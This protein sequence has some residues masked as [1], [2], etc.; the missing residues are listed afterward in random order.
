MLKIWV[1]TWNRNENDEPPRSRTRGASI[2]SVG[3]HRL[4][5]HASRDSIA[6]LKS[7]GISNFSHFAARVGQSDCSYTARGSQWNHRPGLDWFQAPHLFVLHAGRNLFVFGLTKGAL[8]SE[9][10][11]CFRSNLSPVFSWLCQIKTHYVF[12]NS[13]CNGNQSNR[14]K[15]ETTYGIN[16]GLDLYVSNTITHAI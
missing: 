15:K 3:L 5:L 1:R 8:P 7:W 2:V 9:S 4:R 14:C 16:H 11:V 6:I 10:G 13:N 12:F